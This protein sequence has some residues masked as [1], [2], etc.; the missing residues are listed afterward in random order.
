[1]PFPQYGFAL[2]LAASLF[3]LSCAPEADTT[4]RQVPE[5]EAGGW[6]M[7]VWAPTPDE[8]FVVGGR[9]ERGAI[10]R[11]LDGSWAPLPV[12]D[13]VGLVNWGFGFGDGEVVFVANGGTALRWD[14]ASF[15]VQETP[16]TEDL[17]GVW[18][19]SPDDLWAVGGS[20]F[21]ES[22]AVIVHW[23]GSAWTQVEL[24]PL[25]RDSRGLF[26]VWGTGADDV[27]AVGHL[28]LVLHWDG[29][30][31]TELFVGAS[32][33]LVS[34]WGTGPDHIVIV[35]GRSNGSVSFWD[36]ETW[37]TEILGPIP[38]LNGVWMRT[39][40]V[41]HVAGTRGRILKVQVPSFE[42]EEA[43]VIDERPFHSIFG[44]GD[45]LIAVGGTIGVP[46]EPYEGLVYERSL[47]GDE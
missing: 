20:G 21:A 39:P 45:R 36:G 4:W 16:T 18:G 22:E 32:N 9:P 31:W 30:T 13:G 23:D 3:L 12:P 27:Y 10:M 38:G 6:G 17:W 25:E 29:A 7:N 33:D 42:Y 28:G 24:P 15:T 37:T 34:L 5:A 44:V 46:F 8:V 41:A 43:P 35:G 1:M 14:G 26:K 11:E 2:W 40:G 47:A 19:A